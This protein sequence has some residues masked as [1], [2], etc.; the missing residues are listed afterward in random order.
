MEPVR[1]DKDWG[2]ELWI[3]NNNLYCGKILHF[4]KGKKCSWHYHK[5]K[6]ETFYVQKGKLK[7]WYGTDNDITKAK[8]I[9]LEVGQTFEMPVGLRHQILGLEE[10]DMFEFSTTHFDSDSHRIIKGD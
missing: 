8:E 6:K 3:A 10:T 4:N 9:I 2:Y 1:H 7:I 5:L